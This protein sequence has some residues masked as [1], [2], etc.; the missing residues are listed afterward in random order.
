[1]SKG[2]RDSSLIQPRI[3]QTNANEVAHLARKTPVKMFAFDL[4]YWNGYDLRNT[5]LLDRK[6]ALAEIVTPG[7]RIQVSEHFM[8]KGDEILEAARQMGL[9]GVIAKEATSKY[10]PKRSRSWLKLKVT[11]QQEFVICGYTHGERATFSSLVLGVYD[12]GKLKY[13]G[14]RRARASMI[15]R[16][17]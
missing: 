17:R 4:L 7:D 14:L 13:V 16:S 10:E 3:H 8:A 5:P 2:D 9:E 15:R 6:R 12:D 11:G 1:M